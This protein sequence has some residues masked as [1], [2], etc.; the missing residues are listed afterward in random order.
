MP[1]K[2]VP[3]GGVGYGWVRRYFVRPKMNLPA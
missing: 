3:L 1:S 2:T